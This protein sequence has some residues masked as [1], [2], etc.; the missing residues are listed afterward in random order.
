MLCLENAKNGEQAVLRRVCFYLF[1]KEIKLLL[2]L[3]SIILI[4]HSISFQ[5]FYSVFK[6]ENILLFPFF[7]KIRTRTACGFTR[8]GFFS[9]ISFNVSNLVSD[10]VLFSDRLQVAWSFT[11]KIVQKF[12]SHFCYYLNSSFSS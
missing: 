6:I 1:V 3:I 5:F 4:I 10:V 9:K 12:H 7:F 11:F 2:P 8:S